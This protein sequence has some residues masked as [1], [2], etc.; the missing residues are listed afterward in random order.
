MQILRAKIKNAFSIEDIDIHIGGRGLC[1]VTGFSKD[2]NDPNGSGKS[3]LAHKAITWGLWG[4]TVIGAKA[5]KVV[6]K[7]S[8]CC[9]VEVDFQGVDGN[10]YRVIRTRKPNKLKFMSLHL[11]TGKPYAQHTQKTEKATQ[12]LIDQTLGRDFQTWVQTDFFGQGRKQAFPELTPAGRYQVLEEILPI[13]ELRRWAEIATNIRKKAEYSLEKYEIDVKRLSELIEHKEASLKEIEIKKSAWDKMHKERLEGCKNELQIFDNEKDKI[14][15]KI[16]D[17]K[18]NQEALHFNPDGLTALDL[19][20]RMIDE[21]H[22]KIHENWYTSM[23]LKS[24]WTARANNLKSQIAQTKQT[25]ENNCPA[26]NNPLNADQIN[27]LKESRQKIEAE[28]KDASQKEIEAKTSEQYWNNERD[29][30]KDS[31]KKLQYQIETWNSTKDRWNTI[32]EDIIREEGKLEKGVRVQILEKL[33]DLHNEKNPHNESFKLEEKAISFYK[34]DYKESKSSIKYWAN[35]AGHLKFWE[36]AFKTDIKIVLLE[37]VC[38]F[39]NAKANTFIKQLGNPQIHIQFDTTIE[40]TTGIKDEFNVK[41]WSDTGGSSWGLFSG[42]EQAL[43]S[44]AIG[45]ALS[46]LAEAQSSGGCGFTV[47]D[48]PFTN[49]GPTNCERLVTF[50]QTFVQGKDTAFIISNESTLKDLI[51]NQIEVEKYEGTTRLIAA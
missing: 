27:K 16:E 39:L 2:E 43:T 47:L 41:A 28:F 25:Y 3:T 48:E 20:H 33:H 4:Q 7:D 32:R 21:N 15:A 31:L 18:K 38:A 40:K 8:D 5:D 1:L 11:D 10:L 34:A 30:V 6:K 51:N 45:L 13:G 46:S 17:L 50:L 42:G 19:K 26:C 44:F 9:S 24:Q 35:H 29:G 22:K 23:T 12:A 37:Q 36:K 49:L 14:K